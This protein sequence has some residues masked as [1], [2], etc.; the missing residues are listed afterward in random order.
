MVGTGRRTP[1][2]SARSRV[3]QIEGEGRSGLRRG[4]Q[5]YRLAAGRVAE[6]HKAREPPALGL[7]GIHRESFGTEPAGMRDVIRAAPSERWF[8]VSTRSKVSGACTP[9]V[10]CRQFGGCQAR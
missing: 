10:G 2:I 7:V 6:R 4:R 9:I 5:V 1:P 8:H 3:P